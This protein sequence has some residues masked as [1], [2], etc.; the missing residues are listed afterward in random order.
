M[1]SCTDRLPRTKPLRRGELRSGAP[2]R[3]VLPLRA[4]VSPVFHTTEGGRVE[5]K[6]GYE[7]AISFH[8]KAGSAG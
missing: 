6:L 2:H 3:Q 5:D 1:V 4:L 7:S 8:G